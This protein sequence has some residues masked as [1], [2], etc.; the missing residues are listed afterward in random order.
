MSALRSPR[1][2][3][4]ARRLGGQDR[5]LPL[6]QPHNS[7]TRLHAHAHPRVHAQPCVYTSRARV[8]A[9]TC[10]SRPSPLPVQHPRRLESRI[11]IS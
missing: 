11:S 3:P 1:P 4:F 5:P 7:K 6:F 2:R 9:N 8:S 10:L